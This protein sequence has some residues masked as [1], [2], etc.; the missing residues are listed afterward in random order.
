MRFL[1]KSISRVGSTKVRGRK[2]VT[3]NHRVVFSPKN[4]SRFHAKSRRFLLKITV[5]FK[6]MV[7]FVV[8]KLQW[9]SK[10]TVGLLQKTQWFPC[11]QHA[12][13][14]PKSCSAKVKHDVPK[15][16]CM[17]FRVNLQRPKCENTVEP[18]VSSQ[19]R[20]P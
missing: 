15:G 20:R 14:M 6:T 3:L 11:K 5:V 1:V 8:K 16:K 13:P 18:T 9:F 17:C 19:C 10:T 4:D 12:K 7:G 2:K